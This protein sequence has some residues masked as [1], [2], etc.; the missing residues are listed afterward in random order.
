MKYL[1][2]IASGLSSLARNGI[3]HRDLKPENILLTESDDVAIA[4]FGL[5]VTKSSFLALSN[6]SALKQNRIGTSGFR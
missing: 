4:D 3:L 2:Q 6:N 5:A 1:R